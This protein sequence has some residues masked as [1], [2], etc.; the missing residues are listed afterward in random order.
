MKTLKYFLVGAILLFAGCSSDKGTEA[1]VFTF[2]KSTPEAVKDTIYAAADLDRMTI[3]I[4]TNVGYTSRHPQ[5]LQKAETP[6]TSGMIDIVYLLEPNTGDEDRIGTVTLSAPDGSGAFTLVLRQAK[7]AG[8]EPVNPPDERLLFEDNFDGSALDMTKW[9]YEPKSGSP[10]NY[11]IVN[12]ADQVQVRDGNLYVRATWDAATKTPKTGAVSTHGKFS[13]EYGEVQVRAKFV[14]SGQGAWPAIWM[15][16]EHALFAGWP[17]CGELDIM[18][19]LNNESRIYSTVHL[20]D[21][22]RPDP[23]TVMPNVNAADYNIYGMKKYPGRIEFYL[24][25]VKTLTIEKSAQ[26]TD[27]KAWPFDTDFYLIINQACADQGASGK[28]FW[29]GLVDNPGSLPFEMAVDWVR[30]Y[31][32]E[33]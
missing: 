18:E 33:E 23:N 9:V 10:W 15:M 2:L 30:V 24:N 25:G 3:R 4:E 11:Y 5:W 8:G 22:F 27:P 28:E 14:R 26:A 7:Q 17:D 21:A 31:R 29:P 13:L 16:P 12:G 1:V 32:N 19:R 20:N 6:E